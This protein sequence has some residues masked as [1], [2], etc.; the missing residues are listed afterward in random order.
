MHGAANGD[1]EARVAALAQDRASAMLRNLTRYP[2]A[3]VKSLE[4]MFSALDTETAKNLRDAEKAR[5]GGVRDYSL[6]EFKGNMLKAVKRG[7]R[8]K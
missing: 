4:G 8:A 1:M 6:T 2:K 5:A 7:A 3:Y